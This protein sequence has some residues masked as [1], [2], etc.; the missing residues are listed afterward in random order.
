MS[1][2]MKFLELLAGRE[3]G[4]RYLKVLLLQQSI[5]KGSELQPAWGQHVKTTEFASGKIDAS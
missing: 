1:S 2:G 3:S 5:Y 4:I